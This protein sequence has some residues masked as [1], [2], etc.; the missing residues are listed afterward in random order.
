MAAL[1]HAPPPFFKRGPAPLAL[2][3]LYVMLSVSLLVIDARFRTLDLLRQALTVITHPLQQLAHAPM[4]L[5]GEAGSYFASVSRLQEENE[6]LR[7]GALDRAPQTLR[8]EQL[9]AENIRLRKLLGVREREHASGQVAR[10]LYGA[11]DPF[12]RRIIIDRG[13]QDEITAGR[14]V[15]DERGIVG[16]VTRVFPFTSEVTL[17]TDKEQAVPVQIVR[18]GLRSV[19]F[20]VG[21]G[22]M[23]LRFMPANADVQD[24]DLL[25]TSGLDGT[26][27]PGF[28]VARVERIERDT[29]YSFARI[30]CAPVAGV[31]NHGEVMVLQPPAALPERPRADQAVDG[32][33]QDAAPRGRKKRP[34][35]D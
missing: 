17:V 22:R 5:L 6:R 12:Q 8:L 15:I 30:H 33:P 29:S 21:G 32:A 18:N 1:D 24:G 14:P 27:L 19:A 16:Q 20:G 4:Q 11:R 25:V 28:P 31:E 7:R 3:T 2:L 10:I 35:R 34:R 23:E 13:Q 9:E 26:F